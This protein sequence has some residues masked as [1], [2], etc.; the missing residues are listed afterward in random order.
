MYATADPSLP[1]APSHPQAQVIY[2]TTPIF[3]TGFAMVTLDASGEAMGLVAW[4]GAAFMLGASLLASVG[5]GMGGEE[6]EGGG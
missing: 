3:A 1:D 4:T 6:T 5:G 2:A